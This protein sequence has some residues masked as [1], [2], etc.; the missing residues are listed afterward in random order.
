MFYFFAGSDLFPLRVCAV[1]VYQPWLASQVFHDLLS[2]LPASRSCLSIRVA[3]GLLS[4]SGA[5]TCW[6]S[7][8]SSPARV[9]QSAQAGPAAPQGRGELC[10]PAC[11]L[12]ARAGPGALCRSAGA[13]SRR[14]EDSGGALAVIVFLLHRERTLK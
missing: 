4:G 8:S 7:R 14:K 3:A 11:P 6:C 13:E 2:L 9:L 12:A 1:S 5:G 10:C